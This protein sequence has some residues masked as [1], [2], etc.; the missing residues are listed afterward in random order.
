[1]N[2]EYLRNYRKVPTTAGVDLLNV[3]ESDISSRLV[4]EPKDKTG[5][6]KPIETFLNR[7]SVRSVP[8][9]TLSGRRPQRDYAGS[10]GERIAAACGASVHRLGRLFARKAPGSCITSGSATSPVLSRPEG[11]GH[12]SSLDRSRSRTG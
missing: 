6:D 5:Q 11:P 1:M 7:S 10:S 4:K 12:D 3:H 9:D 8:T 2:R